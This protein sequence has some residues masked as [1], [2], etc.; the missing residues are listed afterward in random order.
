MDTDNAAVM[1]GENGGPDTVEPE[2]NIVGLFLDL[3]LPSWI[4]ARPRS[5]SAR[6]GGPV[7]V[8]LERENLGSFIPSVSCL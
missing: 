7:T 5:C 4:Q 2:R 3:M 8:E 6:T 1:F